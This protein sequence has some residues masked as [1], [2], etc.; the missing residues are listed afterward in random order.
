VNCFHGLFQYAFYNAVCG[1]ALFLFIFVPDGEQRG[2]LS[3]NRVQVNNGHMTV[4][5]NILEN[6]PI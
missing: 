4:M 3:G 5:L 6:V 2:F 1:A